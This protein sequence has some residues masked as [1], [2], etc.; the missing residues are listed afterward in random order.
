M[1]RG[2]DILFNPPLIRKESILSPVFKESI[3]YP[4]D[5]RAFHLADDTF[6]VAD[7]RSMY[8]KDFFPPGEKAEQIK[9]SNVQHISDLGALAFGP[10]AETVFY[11]HKELDG[12]RAFP[13]G[14]DGL[15]S[16][17]RHAFAAQNSFDQSIHG[18]TIYGIDDMGDLYL[19]S[20]SSDQSL[21]QTV[22]YDGQDEAVSASI[23]VPGE[24]TLF[25]KGG[26]MTLAQEDNVL[27]EIRNDLDPKS[28]YLPGTE[29]FLRYQNSYLFLGEDCQIRNQAE[30]IFPTG[31]EVR[32]M[33]VS[34]NRLVVL[35]EG[36]TLLLFQDGKLRLEEKL[37]KAYKR[38]LLDNNNLLLFGGLAAEGDHLD[39][40][41]LYDLS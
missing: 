37:K 16:P 1:A 21:W 5:G 8:R 7:D 19:Q 33:D 26:S 18:I 22:N 13:M 39:Q 17:L 10:E 2:S 24:G 6:W 23:T 3:Y 11:S 15:K 40:A 32:D 28:S 12:Q 35:Q 38:V 29:K 14:E 36:N 34:G 31:G 20:L 9:A 41:D 27:V 30:E 4:W 25:F